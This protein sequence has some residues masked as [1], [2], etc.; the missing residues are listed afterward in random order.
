M[1]DEQSPDSASSDS[2]DGAAASGNAEEDL[3]T[4]LAEAASLSAD[5]STGVG[6]TE[7]QTT[8]D[9]IEPT[10]GQADEVARDLDAELTEMERLLETASSDLGAESPEE[11]EEKAEEEAGKPA[12]S[13]AA[14]AEI[15]AF[16]AE[17]T[18]HEPGDQPDGG[19]QTSS[20]PSAPDQPTPP[21]P[22]RNEGEPGAGAEEI[23]ALEAESVQAEPGNQPDK[24]SPDGPAPRAGTPPSVGV[25]G[26]GKVGVVGQGG[27]AAPQTEPTAQSPG[28]TPLAETFEETRAESKP[29][30][31]RSITD[32]L[33]PL[34][35]P[36]CEHCTRLLE[37][38][39]R[40]TGRV[41]PGTRRI[42]GW[43][44]LATV[45][46]AAFVFITSLL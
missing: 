15:P 19:E 34:V 45:G 18:P 13:A 10:A 46:T 21:A 20:L 9:Q 23:S 4:A 14:T 43:A 28:P 22:E 27:T 31:H 8:E 25:V 44:A 33:S 3:D 32:L 1:T 12:P 24:P 2:T 39:D 11:E 41:S 6:E 26:T 7:N 40:P 36:A 29:N 5:L 17:F 30:P 38:L 35:L 42:I 16:M 37:I